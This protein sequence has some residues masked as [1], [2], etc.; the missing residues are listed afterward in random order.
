M[1]N[2]DSLRRRN[3]SDRQRNEKLRRKVTVIDP[4]RD[5]GTVPQREGDGIFYD[6][7]KDYDPSTFPAHAREAHTRKGRTVTVRRINE[8]KIF[9]GGDGKMYKGSG[10]DYPDFIVCQ[11][12]DCLDM[13]DLESLGDLIADFQLIIDKHPGTTNRHCMIFGDTKSQ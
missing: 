13:L 3:A 5:E 2:P 6:G 10:K 8:L 12:H 9:R 1:L 11:Q 4:Q 7:T